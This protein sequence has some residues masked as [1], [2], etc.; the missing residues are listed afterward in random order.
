MLKK[1]NPKSET[2]WGLS[3]YDDTYLIPFEEGNNQE[4]TLHNKKYLMMWSTGFL[5]TDIEMPVIRTE[6]LWF[7]QVNWD[8]SS[9][10]ITGFVESKL[11]DDTLTVD[12]YETKDSLRSK[13][14]KWNSD[15][16]YWW[17]LIKKDQIEEERLW[18][19]DNVYNGYFQG[20]VDEIDI[21]DKYK[22]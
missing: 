17:K 11:V 22:D 5:S 13:Y 10:E 16:R 14:Y 21:K 2:N 12:H 8:V 15:K 19:T 3:T 7:A 6:T 18:L 9:K 4:N 1:T 20:I